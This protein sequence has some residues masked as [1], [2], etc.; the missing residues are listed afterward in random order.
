[1][2]KN[3]ESP[4]DVQIASMNVQQQYVG[5]PMAPGV[6]TP[7]ED[8]GSIGMLPAFFKTAVMSMI[9]PRK[10]LTS[11]RRPE[12]PNDAR[13][14]AIICGV[15][16]GLAWVINDYVG[17]ARGRQSFDVVSDGEVWVLHFAMGLVGT[18]ALLNLISRL[19]YKLVAA[20]DVRAKTPQVLTYNVYAYCLGPSI[21]AVI[22]FGIGPLLAMVWIFLLFI[23]GAV[24]RLAV[25]VGGAIVCN[26]FAAG[27]ML[28]AAAVAYYLLSKLY[29]WLY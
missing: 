13:A 28:V 19:F 29:G 9:A 3:I 22:P 7:W 26:V 20:G 14:F 12:T 1:M 2:A 10:L 4:E 5:N 27:G 24:V 8:R 21:L 18:W 6:G 16:W 23:Y 11:I 25:K 15:F 17:F